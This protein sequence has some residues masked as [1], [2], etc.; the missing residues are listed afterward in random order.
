MVTSSTLDDLMRGSEESAVPGR[1]FF[2]PRP[3]VKDDWLR[4]RKAAVTGL[5]GGV[6]FRDEPGWLAPDCPPVDGEA[7][8]RVW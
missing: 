7:L 4:L 1:W 2:L 3:L 5:C 6:R 8:W